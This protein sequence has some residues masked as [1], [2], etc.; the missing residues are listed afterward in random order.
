[1]ITFEDTLSILNQITCKFSHVSRM[2]F[3]CYKSL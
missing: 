3:I 2:A 1:M